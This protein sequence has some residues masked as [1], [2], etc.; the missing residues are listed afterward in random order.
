MQL[1]KPIQDALNDQINLEQYS[2]NVYLAMA[3]D[4]AAANLLGIEKWMRKQ[5]E[6]ESGH[7]AKF[8]DYVNDRGGRVMLKLIDQPKNE[9]PTPLDA[10]V[11]ALGHENR[12]SESIHELYGLA[13]RERDYATAVFLEWFLKEQVEEEKRVQEIISW[14]KLAGKDPAS[15][16]EIDEHLGER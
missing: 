3:N 5:W 13:M 8:Q 2:A 10:F 16:L 4:F 7:A 9:Y 15:L 12:V 11:A 14:L 1:S 6:E